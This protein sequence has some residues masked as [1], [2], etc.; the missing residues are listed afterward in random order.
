MAWLARTITLSAQRERRNRFEVFRLAQRVF[1]NSSPADHPDVAAALNGH[2]R[3]RALLLALER[4][5]ITNARTWA[6][7]VEAA[8]HVSD[9]SD[10]TRA[11]IVS[12]Q[13]VIGL[14][15]RIRHMRALDVA[16]ADGVLAA[17]AAAVQGD[18]KVSRSIARWI[19]ATLVPALPPLVRPDAWTRATAY[20]STILQAMAGPADRP[21]PTIDWEGLTY[22]VDVVAAE[23]ARLRAVRTQLR[24]PGLDAAIDSETARDLAAAL[25][26]LLYAAAAGD[27]EGAIAL[28]PELPAR[29]DLGLAA[30]SIVRDMMPWAPPE[31]R[32]GMGPWRVQGALIGLDLG[33]SRLLVRR[34]ADQQMPPAPTLT[35]NDLATLARTIVAMVPIELA[36]ADRNEV[37]A[38]IARGRARVAAAGRSELDALAAEVKMSAVARHVLPWVG[39]RQPEHVIDMFSLRDL[40]WLGRPA[41]TTK[42]L[43][44]WGVAAEGLDGRRT[45]AMPP[46]APWDDFAGRSEAGQMSTQ[47]PDITLRLV[48]ETAR[49]RLPAALVPSL[50]AYAIGDYFHD[51]QIRF[52]DDWWRMTRQARAISATR[53]E[54]YVAALAGTGALRTQ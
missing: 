7:L 54:D 10:D 41:L 48:E 16:G 20:E 52:A 3:F 37:A 36:D 39:A 45:L 2:R 11:S 33:L 27:P 1:H 25:T 44:R 23:H 40:L 5:Q 26:A 4:M 43:D 24:S 15:E 9:E 30:T 18:R 38:A 31:E 19:T 22:K 35:L 21:A 46:P 32:Q 14:V 50:L 17:L 49:L 51:V 47:A 53:I 34:V 6:A 8:D 28:S 12:F 42:Q 13:A 29:H